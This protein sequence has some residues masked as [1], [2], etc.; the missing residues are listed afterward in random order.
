[1]KLRRRQT[2]TGEAAATSRR[3]NKLAALTNDQLINQIEQHVSVG[4]YVA[5]QQAELQLRHIEALER[6]QDASE[7]AGK[8]LAT[9][10][11]WLIVF[12]IALVGLTI[13]VVVLTAILAGRGN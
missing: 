11:Q 5:D 12:T 3:T 7:R 2:P 13:A 8:R 6:F 9:L 1:M 10:T 4:G